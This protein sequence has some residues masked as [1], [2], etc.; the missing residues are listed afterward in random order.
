MK[1]HRKKKDMLVDIRHSVNHNFTKGPAVI[2]QPPA[3]AV[4]ENLVGEGRHLLKPPC[5]HAIHTGPF[6]LPGSEQQSAVMAHSDRTCFSQ[7]KTW[8][9]CANQPLVSAARLPVH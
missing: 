6:L 5:E 7:Y 8:K 9:T 2:L 4:A 1:K 3:V